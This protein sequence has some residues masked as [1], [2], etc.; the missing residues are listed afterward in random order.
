MTDP[1][2]WKEYLR[3]YQELKPHGGT[4]FSPWIKVGLILP[5]CCPDQV[6]IGRLYS[7]LLLWKQKKKQTESHENKY[8]SLSSFRKCRWLSRNMFVVS[9]KM[10]KTLYRTASQRKN[11]TNNLELSA[12]TR[13]GPYDSDNNQ[14]VS[15]YFFCGGWSRATARPS[16]LCRFPS[17][18]PH[19]RARV[20]LIYSNWQWESISHS[21]ET[22]NYP[23]VDIS[24][25]QDSL[26]R[27]KTGFLYWYRVLFLH[28]TDVFETCSSDWVCDMS[29]CA[30]GVSFIWC[31]CIVNGV[32]AWVHRQSTTAR[33]GEWVRITYRR[34]HTRVN[35]QTIPWCF[36]YTIPSVADWIHQNS[37]FNS[38]RQLE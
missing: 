21:G 38:F 7:G 8:R 13:W 32:F 19:R 27:N 3:L 30:A 11:S 28:V 33:G 36:V 4:V 35:T 9:V 22:Y 26:M 6:W 20:Q 31:V 17:L 18:S 2:S 10:R 14:T 25:L 16:L 29:Y 23:P 24:T 15:V 34:T 12:A 1:K 5:G 37:T